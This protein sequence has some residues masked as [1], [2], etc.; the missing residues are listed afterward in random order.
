[1]DDL[2]WRRGTSWWE[3]LES[4]ISDFVW[5]IEEDFFCCYGRFKE[6][7]GKMDVCTEGYRL[8]GGSE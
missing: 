1:V 4:L 5:A 2:G 3:E 6:K 8:E 7:L